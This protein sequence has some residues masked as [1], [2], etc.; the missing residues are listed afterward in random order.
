MSVKLLRSGSLWI[1]GLIL[2]ASSSLQAQKKR[3]LLDTIDSLRAQIRDIQTELS[4]AQQREKA[5]QAQAELY[6]K[7]AAELKSANATLLQNLNNF[8]QV[9]SKNTSA[10]NQT[11]SSLEAKE[12]QLRNIVETFSRNDSV[13]IALLSQAKQT[14]GATA[15]LKI[16]SGGLVIS[17][18]LNEVFTEET[19]LQVSDAGTKWLEGIAKLAELYPQLNLTVEG[20]SMTGEIALAAGQATAVM[21]TLRDTLKISESRLSSRGR[22][23][24]FSEGVDVILYPNYRKFYLET[25]KEIQ[26]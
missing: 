4:R 19:G 11:L 5:S 26:N 9:S 15:K 6:E 21:N 17:G 25:R 24:N 7:E 1:L 18:G 22:D 3:E 8:A 20:L 16:S 2:F 13:I 12:G 10:L 14:L 23:G